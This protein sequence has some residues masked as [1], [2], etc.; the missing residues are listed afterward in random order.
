MT[1]H[2]LEETLER[3]LSHLKSCIQGMAGLANHAL[4]TCVEA[5]RNR[6]RKLAFAIILRDQRIDE[7]EKEVDRVCL[8]FLIRHQPVGTQLR[9]V[10]AAI[11]INAGLE[12]IGDYAESIA[13]QIVKTSSLGPSPD[14][15]QFMELA[16]LA[17]PMFR[18]AMAAY[19]NQDGDLARR[20]MEVESRADEIRNKIDAD[21]IRHHKEGRIP[22]EA[23]T[24]YMTVARRFERVSD[25]A[26]SICEETLYVCTGDFAKHRGAGTWRILFVDEQSACL[27]PMACAIGRSLGHTRFEFDSAGLTSRPLDPF[28]RSFLAGKRLEGLLP[29]PQLLEQVASPEHI[30]VMIELG[31]LSRAI[32]PAARSKA[33]LLQWAA[34]DPTGVTGNPEE[35]HG[36]YERAFQFL[37]ENIRDLVDAVLGDNPA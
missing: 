15:E 27:A 11:K 12:R 22:L 28:T 31:R 6:N 8:E 18:D 23:L 5:L 10:Y 25:Q 3:D 34:P 36:S 9:F 32:A 19:L 13:R 17:I 4:E 16:G 29:A 26:K 14:L 37:S 2:H 33:I 24:R 30:Q 35:V 1:T 7:M 20:T 21:L